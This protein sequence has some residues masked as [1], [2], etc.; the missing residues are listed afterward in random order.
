M[1]K[2]QCNCSVLSKQISCCS[3]FHWV[4]I[5]FQQIR[6]FYESFM[7]NFRVFNSSGIFFGETIDGSF[8]KWISDIFFEKHFFYRTANLSGKYS[9][10]FDDLFQ[11]KYETFAWCFMIVSRFSTAFHLKKKIREWK[12][13]QKLIVF[14]RMNHVNSVAD[15]KLYLRLLL[16]IIVKIKFFEDLYSYKK[17]WYFSYW[18]AYVVRGF[19]ANDQK[20]IQYLKK[21]K[22]VFFKKTLWILFIT[23]LIQKKHWWFGRY[24]KSFQKEFLRWFDALNNHK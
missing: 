3:Q 13:C 4:L 19:A 10:H 9:Q 24:M 23:D 7:A 6:W 1:K 14:G 21:V 17:Q 18:A 20:W 2:F 12:F 5:N 8:S 16:I 15:K 11:I 22:S